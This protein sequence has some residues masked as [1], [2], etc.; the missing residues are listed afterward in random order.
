VHEDDIVHKR[1]TIPKTY[2]AVCKQAMYGHQ[3]GSRDVN[4]IFVRA[5]F[6]NACICSKYDSYSTS[7]LESI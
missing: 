5:F 4:G 7:P 3:N 2:A 6:G 1:K